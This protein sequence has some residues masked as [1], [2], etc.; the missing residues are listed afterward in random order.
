MEKYNVYSII[1]ARCNS[2]FDAWNCSTTE[3]QHELIFQYSGKTLDEVDFTSDEE[4][5]RVANKNGIV[6]NYC[7]L[8]AVADRGK[9]T[10]LFQLWGWTRSNRVVVELQHAVLKR[11]KIDTTKEI[12]S[13]LNRDKNDNFITDNLVDALAIIDDFLLQLYADKY[14][15]MFYSNPIESATATATTETETA[16][17]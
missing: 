15:I 11:N 3:S 14:T 8:R 12:Y 16:T 10:T 13:K 2:Q 6:N 4:C 1:N 17:A 5:A 7:A 9:Y